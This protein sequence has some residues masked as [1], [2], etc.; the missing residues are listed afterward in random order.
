MRFF[1]PRFRLIELEGSLSEQDK[2][3]FRALRESGFSLEGSRLF[4][5]GYGVDFTHPAKL[6]ELCSSDDNTFI[7]ADLDDYSMPFCKGFSAMT[8]GKCR[9]KD[10]KGHREAV[11]RFKDRIVRFL[12][13]VSDLNESIPEEAK[14]CDSYFER[15]F[16]I[17]R[18]PD[19]M[20]TMMG[21]LKPGGLL[22]T[23]A[24][25]LDDKRLER[26]DI[27]KKA[28]KLGFYKNFT[29]YRK[30]GP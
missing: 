3:A 9:I 11:F 8:G 24:G 30:E 2:E 18:E 26:I 1:K 15:A 19:F 12:F 23:D 27:P 10:K 16:E 22:L 6:I 13:F 25:R 7:L 28:N 20:E 5:P 17:C 14:G 29:V 4:Y 21:L